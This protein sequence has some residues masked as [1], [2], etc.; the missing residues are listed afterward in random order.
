VRYG[1]IAPSK[2]TDHAIYCCFEH[3]CNK[4]R[5]RFVGKFRDQPPTSEQIMDTFRE[6]ILGAYLISRGF[7]ARY[8]HSVDGETP[9]WCI[10]N[11][12]R[13]VIAII[14]VT[15]FHI[16]AVTES[17]IAK[18][19]Q[20]GGMSVYWRD[21]NRNN[22]ERLYHCILSKM[23]KYRRLTEK[24]GVPYIVGIFPDR[25]TAVELEEVRAR[26]LYAEN[27]GLFELCPHVSGVLCSEQ[28]DQAYSFEY[29]RSPHAL[30]TF[31]IPNGVLSLAAEQGH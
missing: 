26:C 5:Q 28:Y 7:Q 4:D 30:R 11:S 22:I 27:S 19:M 29:E 13:A 24:L 15:T 1:Q 8:E 6:L 14:E 16:D 23:Q 3:L 2:N 17:D 18:Q 21:G 31:D 9:D 10:L 20:T 12:G 25:K